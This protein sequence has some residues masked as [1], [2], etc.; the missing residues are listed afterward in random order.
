ASVHSFYDSNGIARL[1]SPINAM[2]RN[3]YFNGVLSN[4]TETSDLAGISGGFPSD[5][6][7]ISSYFNSD[8]AQSDVLDNSNGIHLT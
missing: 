1:D 5:T 6:K 8:K 4:T 7:L 3:C 2:V